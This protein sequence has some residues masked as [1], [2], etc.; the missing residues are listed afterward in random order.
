L[1]VVVSGFSLVRM[2]FSLLEFFLHWV[3]FC[4]RS[5]SSSSVP[6]KLREFVSRGR[7]SYEG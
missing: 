4:H 5:S 1:A 3:F 6:E 2:G 7:G